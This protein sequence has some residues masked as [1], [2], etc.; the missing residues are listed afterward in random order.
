MESRAGKAE[1]EAVAVAVRRDRK[2]R[3][4]IHWNALCFVCQTDL[5]ETFKTLLPNELVFEASRAL[6]FREGEAFPAD[7][8]AFCMGAGFTYHSNKKK[9]QRGAAPLRLGH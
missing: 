4:P 7:S 5:I 8:V 1:V 2:N 3:P 9:Q 6:V